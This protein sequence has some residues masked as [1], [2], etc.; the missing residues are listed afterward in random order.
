[1]PSRHDRDLDAES[2]EAERKKAMEEWHRSAS[3]ELDAM[4]QAF[5]VLYQ[6]PRDSRM[7]ALRWLEARLD[8]SPFYGEPPF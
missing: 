6:L 5:D 2:A 4:T 7:R 3:A 1:M 8:N